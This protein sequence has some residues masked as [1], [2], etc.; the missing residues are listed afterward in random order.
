MLLRLKAALRPGSSLVVILADRGFGRARGNLA[1]EC[2][3]LGLDYLVR[4]N[5]DV[6]VK[7]GGSGGSGGWRGNLKHYPI[8]RG[9][10]RS[11]RDVEYRSDGV[12][13]TNLIARWKKG[14]VG[15]KDQP[16]YLITSLTLKRR[17]ASR[18]YSDLYSRPVR[19]RGAI[20]GRQERAPGAGA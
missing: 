4:I 12:V 16:W 9:V 7:A 18:R 8:R 11:W 2:K 19:H 14:L 1:V 6:I 17:G 20:S 15:D 3:R 13:T 10:C 5:A